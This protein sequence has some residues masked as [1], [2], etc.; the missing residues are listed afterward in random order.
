MWHGLFVDAWRDILKAQKKFMGLSNMKIAERANTTEGVVA[1][2]LADGSD[3][4]LSQIVAIATALET[5]FEELFIP[6]L[7]NGM[8]I[9]TLIEEYA[10]ITEENQSLR[11][12]NTAL[13]IKVDELRGKIDTLKDEIIETQRHYIKLKSN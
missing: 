7:P 5:P 13:R 12:D 8:K 9:K 10:K 2:A 4:P 1:R 6:S 3:P 11:E